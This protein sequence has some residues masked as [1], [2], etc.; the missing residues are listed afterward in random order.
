MIIKLSPIRSDEELSIIKQG[1]TLILNGE[2]FDFTN[3]GAGD[4]LPLEA[5]TSTWFA[6]AVT[7]TGDTLELTLRF[8]LPANFS[9]EQAFP[10]PL[11]NVPDGVVQLP[12]P[13]PVPVVAGEVTQ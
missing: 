11:L 3:V 10:V 4:T 2:S 1:A 13:L 9:P 6:D 5:I 7:R 8:P 12:Q